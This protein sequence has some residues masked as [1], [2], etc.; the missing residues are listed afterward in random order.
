MQP[1]AIRFWTGWRPGGHDIL[2]PPNHETF[3]VAT[4]E[5]AVLRMSAAAPGGWSHVLLQARARG[6]A[7][8][9]SHPR[10]IHPLDR[11]PAPP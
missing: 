6:T 9:T 8:L 5:G 4:I 2:A 11:P 1:A 7:P 10:P 3:V